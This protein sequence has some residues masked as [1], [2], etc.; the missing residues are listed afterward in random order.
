MKNIYLHKN[1]PNNKKEYYHIYCEGSSNHQN[2]L[3]SHEI[4]FSKE[5]PPSHILQ[6]WFANTLGSF[7]YELF[8]CG[9]PTSL[10][11]CDFPSMFP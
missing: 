10:T 9:K 11:S 4:V 6:K 2:Y 8:S 1:N 7:A 5:S 3:S